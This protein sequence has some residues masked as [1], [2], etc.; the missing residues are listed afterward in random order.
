MPSFFLLRRF[1]LRPTVVINMQIYTF[2]KS[3]DSN[4]FDIVDIYRGR[5]NERTTICY[6]NVRLFI[7]GV[8][9]KRRQND[10]SKKEVLLDPYYR[11]TYIHIIQRVPILGDILKLIAHQDVGSFRFENDIYT[12]EF[13]YD[14]EEQRGKLYIS[15]C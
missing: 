9:I 13:S 6:K 5:T 3:E 12:I 15:K 1:R 10:G 7:H 2:A 4:H 8:T 14:K 11:A